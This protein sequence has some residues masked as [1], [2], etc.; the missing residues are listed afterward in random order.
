VEGQT[1]LSEQASGFYLGESGLHDQ[2]ISAQRLRERVIASEQ[3]AA[4]P[5]A[6]AGHW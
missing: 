3:Q 6:T 2:D 5:I 4:C 1:H